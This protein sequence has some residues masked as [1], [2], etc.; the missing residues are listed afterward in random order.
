MTPYI[1]RQVQVTGIRD[2]SRRSLSGLARVRW[3]CPALLRGITS[4]IPPA[5]QPVSRFPVP[6]CTPILASLRLTFL[7]SGLDTARVLMPS[8][9]THYLL[10]KHK[11]Y[12]TPTCSLT[13]DG[14]TRTHLRLGAVTPTTPPCRCCPQVRRMHRRQN[15]RAQVRK[16][17]LP[18]N[19]PQRPQ[20]WKRLHNL[21]RPHRRRA[22]FSLGL[23]RSRRIDLFV[24]SQ[25]RRWNRLLT[26]IFV[27]HRHRGSRISSSGQPRGSQ[28][29]FTPPPPEV[30]IERQ[31][32]RLPL[33]Q[34]PFLTLQRPPLLAP[35]TGLLGPRTLVFR[36]SRHPPN[37]EEPQRPRG[38][39]F[40]GGIRRHR[41]ALTIQILDME[42]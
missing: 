16:A 25:P 12:P 33:R 6:P 5:H 30:R 37:A 32:R 23:N 17:S 2:P 3:E 42:T 27:S 19:H 15:L 1:L 7:R 21:T 39:R 13:P 18:R 31:H 9:I 41:S 26:L 4:S 28:P 38:A 36:L 35:P 20:R 40:H 10:R 24:R 11:L 34:R 14:V 8:H 22:T 29:W